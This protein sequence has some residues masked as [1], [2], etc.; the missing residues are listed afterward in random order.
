MHTNLAVPV[1]LTL[2]LNYYFNE[3]VTLADTEKDIW[4]ETVYQN[5]SSEE[6]R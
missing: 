5:E 4:F 2:F 1:V 6:R 3:A